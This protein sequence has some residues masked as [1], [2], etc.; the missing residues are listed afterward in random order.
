M[1]E[2]INHANAKD[3]FTIVHNIEQAKQ[4]GKQRKANKWLNKLEQWKRGEFTCTK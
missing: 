4:K 1:Q 2:L 3:Y